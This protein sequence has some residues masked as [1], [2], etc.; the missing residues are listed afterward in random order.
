MQG[1]QEMKMKIKKSKFQPIG[2]QIISDL[3]MR[4]TFSNSN[5]KLIFFFI[6]II[7]KHKDPFIPIYQT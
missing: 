1:G 5:R 4:L 3:D 2:K 6:G 7:S